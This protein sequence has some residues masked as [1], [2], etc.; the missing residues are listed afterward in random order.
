MMR[1]VQP[2]AETPATIGSPWVRLVVL[3]CSFCI[4]STVFLL[5][6]RLMVVIQLK[7]FVRI[8]SMFKV[9]S[10]PLLVISPTLASNQG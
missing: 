6:D 5:C 4:L 10:I 9:S 7:S 8:A 2:L 1:W 3:N